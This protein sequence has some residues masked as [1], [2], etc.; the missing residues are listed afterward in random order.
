MANRKANWT[1]PDGLVVG[2]GTRAVETT[3]SAKAP[4]KGVEQQ[5]VVKIKGTD[6]PASDVSAQLVHA[7]TI[8]AGA[9]LKSAFLQVDTAFAGATATLDIGVYKSVDGV[10]V[11]EDGIAS[12]IAVATLIADYDAA[13]A[14]SLIGTTLAFASKVGVSY[15][16]A[17]FTAGNAT[18]TVT[19]VVPAA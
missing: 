15:D 11:A 2:F 8:P 1:N 5:V 18:L 7:P 19:Y 9:F 13:M 6:I 16:T 4:T 12:N 14:G 10:V 3:Y 17:A